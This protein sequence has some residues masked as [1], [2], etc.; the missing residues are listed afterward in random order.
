MGG[1]WA[2]GVRSF[3]THVPQLWAYVRLISG[4]FLPRNRF[5][6]RRTNSI[7]PPNKTHTKRWRRILANS[8]RDE[9]SLDWD[10]RG[11]PPKEFT[12]NSFYALNTSGEGLG[13]GVKEPSCEILGA[14]PSSECLIFG[15]K[16]CRRRRVADF[17]IEFTIWI[18][19]P[20]RVGAALLF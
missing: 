19:L 18:E 1:R 16:C 13:F 7:S 12:T 17:K 3:K 9:A 14:A 5:R 15:H 8:W 6:S 20:D 11:V 10:V 4:N 2:E